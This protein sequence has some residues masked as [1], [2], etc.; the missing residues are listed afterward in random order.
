MLAGHVKSDDNP[1]F[2]TIKTGLGQL[3]LMACGISLPLLQEDLAL[4]LVEG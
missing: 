1:M 3:P 4:L 2:L